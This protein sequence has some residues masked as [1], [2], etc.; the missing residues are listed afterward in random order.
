MSDQA[1]LPEVLGADEHEAVS[2]RASKEFVRDSIEYTECE[3]VLGRRRDELATRERIDRLLFDVARD[4][5]GATNR[6]AIER[7]VCERLAGSELYEFA[8]IGEGVFEGDAVVPRARAGD[9]AG[10]VEAVDAGE[11]AISSVVERALYTGEM[12]VVTVDDAGFEPWRTDAIDCDGRSVVAVPLGYGETV[13]GVL[14]VHATRPDAFNRREQAAFELLG[15]MVGFTINALDDRRLLFADAVTELELRLASG[16]QFLVDHS[17]RFDCEL[18][19]TG[20]LATKSG[21]WLLYVT[22]N[23][24]RPQALRDAAVDD[25]ATERIRVVRDTSEEGLLEYRLDGSSLLQVVA[26]AGAKLRDAH[27][28]SGVGRVVVEAPRDTD[29]R[30][31]MW[32]LQQGCPHAELLAKHERDRSVAKG[33]VPCSPLD[34]L[35]DR[36]QETLEAAYHA[37]YFD[38]PRESTT[39]EIAESM[40]IS[41]PTLHRHLRRAEKQLLSAFLDPAEDIGQSR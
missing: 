10:Y 11:R 15:E 9:D 4:L 38:W 21:G 20:S 27:A 29:I 32:R 2:G 5:I 12:Q 36:Q 31:L 40:E 18:S 30:G 8:W 13:Y 7:S 25:A 24:A 23:G 39:E 17:E 34:R 14:G 28:A 41:S 33:A 37:G 3:R 26:E 16:D 22:V 1:I 35:T 19:V 6:E